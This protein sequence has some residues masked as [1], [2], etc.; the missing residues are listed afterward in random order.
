MYSRLIFGFS[1]PALA[2]SLGLARRIGV[3][4]QFGDALLALRAALGRIGIRPQI[5]RRWVLDDACR[6]LGAMWTARVGSLGMGRRIGV[7]AQF[8]VA[9]FALLTALGRIGIRPQICYGVAEIDGGDHRLPLWGG[10]QSGRRALTWT[11]FD[12]HQGGVN[13]SLNTIIYIAISAFSIRAK[14]Q[15]I[16]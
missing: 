3:R 7:R 15:F 2:G 14:G 11:C 5:C 13:G 12:C 4:A 1:H 8:G 9:F 16:V 10:L 6:L